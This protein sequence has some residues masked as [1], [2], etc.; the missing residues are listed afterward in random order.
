VRYLRL[1]PAVAGD[2]GP[3]TEMDTT[4]VPPRVK[5]LHYEF[6]TWL[7][8]ALVE[9]YPIFLVTKEAA[10]GL[11][12]HNFSGFKIRPVKVTT[13]EV[14]A[15]VHSGELPDFVWLDVHGSPG[16]DDL[17]LEKDARLVVAEP[18]LKVLERFGIP[19]CDVYPV[20][21]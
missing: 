21:R 4:H 11:L 8:D 19:N 2:L 3:D 16:A 7:G 9:S 17:G 18:V 6:D 14:F 12:H 10:D 1:S 13:S 20:D 5:S 15:E